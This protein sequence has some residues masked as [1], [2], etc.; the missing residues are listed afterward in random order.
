MTI[1][2]ITKICERCNEKIRLPGKYTETSNITKLCQV[3][4]PNGCKTHTF[5]SLTM[6][7]WK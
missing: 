1:D 7:W 4:C 3:T 5:D 6:K 2:N